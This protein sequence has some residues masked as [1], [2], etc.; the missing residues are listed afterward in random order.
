MDGM[1]PIWKPPG[2][3]SYDVIRVFKKKFP[4]IKVG[5]AG[6]LDPFAEGILILMLGKG[7]KLFNEIQKWGKRYRAVARLGASSDTLDV[8]GL[9]KQVTSFEIQDSRKFKEQII[10]VARYFVGEVEQEVPQYSAAKHKGMPLY[11]YARRGKETPK[12]TKLITIYDIKVGKINENE[13][14]L[15]VECSSGTYIR[16]LSYDIFKKLGIDSYLVKLVREQVGKIGVEACITVKELE[17]EDKVKSR[18][19]P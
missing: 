13:V 12:K 19:Q 2:I 14:E 7:T 4:G 5:H 6:T 16:Q 8:T 10:E 3:T 18:L 15:A 1:L 9:E 17:N 11:K